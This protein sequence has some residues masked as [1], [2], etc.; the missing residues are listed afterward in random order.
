MTV[1]TFEAD[2]LA[3]EINSIARADFDSSK[4]KLLGYRV[5]SLFALSK[6]K[7]DFVKI[8]SLGGPGL[9][10]CAG[11]FEGNLLAS[12]GNCSRKRCP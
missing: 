9:M 8:G 2:F 7:S 5:N 10:A 11:C 1:D 3:V 6:S 4:T 12:L